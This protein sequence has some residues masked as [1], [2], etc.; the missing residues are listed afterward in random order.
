M[1]QSKQTEIWSADWEC[2][3]LLTPPPRPRPDPRAAVSV[4]S[5]IL[6]Y[7]RPQDEH[8]FYHYCIIMLHIVLSH[9]NVVLFRVIHFD[10]WNEPS[11]ISETLWEHFTVCERQLGGGKLIN[12]KYFRVRGHIYSS[13]YCAQ[14][15]SHNE[16]EEF[17]NGSGS[18]Y[19]TEC[20]DT[21]CTT[22]SAD[23]F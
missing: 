15:S 19:K 9:Y 1:S 6:E 13:R 3:K 21:N 16:R 5:S 10:S 8:S 11:N 12:R 18:M 4:G 23:M 14:F 7:V 20:T 17:L 2:L 22:F